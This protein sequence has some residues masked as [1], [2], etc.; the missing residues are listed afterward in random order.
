MGF[1]IGLYFGHFFRNFEINFLCYVVAMSELVNY[2]ET[3]EKFLN[4]W[5]LE[6]LL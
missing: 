6:T 1:N 4:F 2:V 5:M 3:T